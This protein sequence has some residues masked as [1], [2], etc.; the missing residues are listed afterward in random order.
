MKPFCFC[1]ETIK[2]RKT[3][4][5]ADFNVKLQ[6]FGCESL[7]KRENNYKQGGKKQ[8]SPLAILPSCCLLTHVLSCHHFCALPRDF[9]LLFFT[10]QREDKET[11]Q[12]Q[13]QA[14]QITPQKNTRRFLITLMIHTYRQQAAQP[15]YSSQ[16]QTAW[17]EGWLL[18]VTTPFHITCSFSTPSAD[19]NGLIREDFYN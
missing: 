17:P 14:I 15:A 8:S 6:R 3:L 16:Q 12:R 11:K 18:L 19:A 10:N 2:N 13:P 1:L 4:K 9:L 5:N 7:K